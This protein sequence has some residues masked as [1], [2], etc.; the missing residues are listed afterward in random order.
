MSKCNEKTQSHSRGDHFIDCLISCSMQME[1]K[2]VLSKLFQN[3]TI[4]LPDNYKLVA[5]ARTT[6]QPKGSVLCTLEVRKQ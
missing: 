1:A 2:V 4:S 5:A 3:Y 6:T